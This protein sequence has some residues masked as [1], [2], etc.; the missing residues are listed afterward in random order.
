MVA[1]GGEHSVIAWLNRHCYCN[2]FF[3]L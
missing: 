1:F 2:C 3:I